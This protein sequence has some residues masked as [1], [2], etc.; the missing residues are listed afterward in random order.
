MF[1]VQGG[2]VALGCRSLTLFHNPHD[3]LQRARLVFSR[4]R[5]AEPKNRAGA[6][7]RFRDQV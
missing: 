3:G 1:S 7:F 4:D 2:L 6:S 5:T